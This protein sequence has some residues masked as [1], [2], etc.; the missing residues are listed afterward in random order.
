[1]YTG[2]ICNINSITAGTSIPGKGIS[3]LMNNVT[4][5]NNKGT[6]TPVVELYIPQKNDASNPTNTVTAIINNS[7]IWGTGTNTVKDDSGWA[8]YR[9]SLVKGLTVDGAGA[10]TGYT[11]ADNNIAP[12]GFSESLFTGFSGGNYTLAGT[13]PELVNNSNGNGLYPFDGSGVGGLLDGAWLNLSGSY[14]NA[15]IFTDLVKGAVYGSPSYY[16]KDATAAL[17]DRLHTTTPGS[18]AGDIYSVNVSDTPPSAAGADQN[19]VKGAYI[20]VGAYEQ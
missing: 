9:H 5:A 4:L 7:V 3:I 2:G 18:T 13:P 16:D 17:G 14:I 20:D 1:M 12:G 15:T 8:E 10:S 11:G 6:V 19:R